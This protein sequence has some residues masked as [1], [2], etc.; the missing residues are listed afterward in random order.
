MTLNKVV[1]RNNTDTDSCVCD[2]PFDCG[3]QQF[4]NP[5][6]VIEQM[7]YGVTDNR[8]TSREKEILQ[9]VIS[10]KTNK[11][12]AHSLCRTERTIE[13]HRNR[14]MHKLNTHNMAELLKK[15]IS[16]GMTSL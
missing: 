6:H 9:L 16:I 2:L 10:G 15:A 7:I 4:S 12:I 8:L 13:Y 14:L 11:E 1:S 3:E 5:D